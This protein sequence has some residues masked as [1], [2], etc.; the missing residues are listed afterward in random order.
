MDDKNKNFE[1]GKILKKIRYN[2]NLN[3][4]DF[5]K[6][7][8]I[9]YSYVA[10]LEKQTSYQGP[11]LYP[12]IDLLYQICDKTNFPFRQF[13]EEAG[14]IE[15]VEIPEPSEIQKIYEKLDL[16]SQ[17][18]LMVTAQTLLKD[19]ENFTEKQPAAQQNWDTD[20]LN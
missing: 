5:A 17:Q 8:G 9:S 14:Y 20:K 15:P 6:K 4:R 13:L 3:T 11:K 2:L 19:I 12:T 7:V 16:K 18:V 1:Y 10:M